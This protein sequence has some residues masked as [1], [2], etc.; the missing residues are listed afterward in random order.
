MID[1]KNKIFYASILLLS[2]VLHACEIDN[3]DGPTASLSGQILDHNG[4]AVQTEQGSGNMRIKLVDTDWNAGNEDIAVTPLY[5]NVQQDGKYINSKVFPGMYAVSLVEGPFYPM[6]EEEVPLVDIRGNTTHDF[7]VTPYLTVEWV[8]E[9]MLTEDNFIVASI[10]FT[11]NARTGMVMP[12]LLNGQLFIARTQYCGNNN[13][14]PQMV[15]SVK[16]IK[17]TDEGVTIEFK[18]TRAVKYTHTSYFVRIG[19]CCNDSYK[20]YNYTSIVKVDV[21]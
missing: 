11:R 18:T 17:N 21:E 14:D 13:Y 5:F 1:M 19:I 20:K 3:Y 8:Q 12:N 9:P 2:L 10:R 7:T 4:K 15:G 6:T 16:S